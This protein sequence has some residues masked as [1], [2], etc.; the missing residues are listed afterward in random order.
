MDDLQ[1]R[2]E[3]D[4]G[5]ITGTFSGDWSRDQRWWRDNFRNRPYAT[6]DRRFEDYEPGYRFGYLA[7]NRYRGC[8]WNDVESNIRTDWDRF[9][10]RG[11]SSWENMKDAVRDAWASITGKR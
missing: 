2:K 6:A 3:S 9:E 11:Q 4:L 7:A 10:G 1:K 5:T 8:T